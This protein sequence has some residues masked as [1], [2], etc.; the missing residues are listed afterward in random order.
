MR[1]TLFWI[2]I[3]FAAGLLAAFGAVYVSPEKAWFLALLGLTYWFWISVNVL[4]V[5]VWLIL[6][7][8]FSLLSLSVIV[9]TFPLHVRMVAPRLPELVESEDPENAVRIMSYNVQLF[10]LYHWKNNISHRNEMFR[11]LREADADIFCFQEYF[12]EETDYF[13]TTDTLVS[14]LNAKNFQFESASSLHGTHHWGAA[15]FSRLPI[16]NKGKI[17]FDRS[18]GNICLYSDVVKGKDTVRI[19]NVHFE[20]NHLETEKIDR[21]A[22]GDSTARIIALDMYRSLRKSYKRRAAQ[23]DLVRKA[24]SESPYPVIVCGD[25]NDTPISYTY[26]QISAGLKDAFLESGSGFGFTYA[27]KIPF[28]RIDYILHD[29]SIR[30]SKFRILKGKKLSDHYPVECLVEFPRSMQTE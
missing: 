7:W 17:K 26:S 12:Y 1:K 23:V 16:V 8:R 4:F 6:K 24:I 29:P 30:S 20:S 18:R 25:F 5:F 9:L 27:G 3:P 19:F 14:V 22:Q 11:F 28:L 10:G 21:L 2:N 15:T 13:E